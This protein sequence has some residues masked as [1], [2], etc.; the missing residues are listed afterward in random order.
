MRHQTVLTYR[1]HRYL[2]IA[3]TLSLA[4]VVAY[5]IAHP[6]TEA[7]APAAFGSSVTGYGLGIVSAALVLWLS[8]YGIRKRRYG[9]GSGTVKGWLSAHVYL[10]ASLIVLATLHTG[11]EFGR[12][13][14]TLAY[15]LML[16]VVFSGFYGIVV[17]QVMPTAITRNLG[18]DTLESL[19]TQIAEQDREAGRLAKQLPEAINGAVLEAARGTVV[20]GGVLTQLS[21]RQRHCPTAAAVAL[22]ERGGRET[23]GDQ[24]RLDHQLYTVL[25][26][27]ASLLARARQ[28]IR[29]KALL[30]LWLVVHV[31]LSI[32]LLVVL[33]AHVVSVLFYW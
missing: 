27:K 10:G 1:R 23:I 22:L 25:L 33:T 28:D 18:D 14:H 29:I 26:R 21:G 12:N 6:G 30:D 4:A 7:H 17:Y 11:F 8:W 13:V 32:A 19:L 15:V 2:K 31:P 20:G 3:G 16:C 24:S 5:L 9:R